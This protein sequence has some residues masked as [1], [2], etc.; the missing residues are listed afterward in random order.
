MSKGYLQRRP[1]NNPSM[2]GCKKAASEIHWIIRRRFGQ[3]SGGQSQKAVRINQFAEA[4]TPG[5][6][7]VRNGVSGKPS[8]LN[9]FTIGLSAQP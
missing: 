9:T 3:I 7:S 4:V 8:A 1:V 2:N 5:Q 6:S